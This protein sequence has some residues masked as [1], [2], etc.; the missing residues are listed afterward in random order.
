MQKNEKSLKILLLN[1]PGQYIYTRD[2]YC[3]KTTKTGYVEHPV[4]FLIL[5]GI[6]SDGSFNIKVLDAIMLKLNTRNCFKIIKNM[7]PDV[8]VFLSGIVSWP[9]DFNFM[10]KIKNLLGS[11]VRLIGTGDIFL[12]SDT[13]NLMSNNRWLDAILFDFTETDIVKFLKGE[14]NVRNIIY[15]NGDSI[16]PAKQNNLENTFHVPV[17][18]HSLFL[19]IKYTFPFARH[20]LYTTLLT[21]F[22]CPFNC[23]FCIYANFHYKTRDLHNVYQ[24]LDVIHK[25]GIKEIFIKDQCFA[26]VPQRAIHICEEMIRKKYDFSWICFIRANQAEE[27][28]LK[29][30]KQAGCHTVIIG[31]ETGSPRIF[32]KFKP[33][34]SHD[35]IRNAFTLCQ[36]LKIETVG[37]FILGFPEETMADIKQ[38]IDFSTTLNCDY[39]SFNI[40]T[41]KIK[42]DLLHKKLLVKDQSGR[43]GNSCSSNLSFAQLRNAQL[44]AVKKFYLR[45]GYLFRR[46]MKIDSFYRL[47]S[48]L[49]H[50]WGLFYQ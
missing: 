9:E 49:K 12:N 38:T 30:M 32:S 6:L 28:L 17:P 13:E 19:N 27:P 4:D 25:L 15:R 7:R 34:L 10:R 42:N 18:N 22:G 50:A 14:H 45:P 20:R 16:V 37:T 46:F 43:I 33:G 35:K 41:S 48:M 23:S 1:P 3:S 21:D 40:F 26:N 31:V 2:Y 5:S 47:N 36:Q 8:I 24:E 11:R 39:A 44:L 29:I